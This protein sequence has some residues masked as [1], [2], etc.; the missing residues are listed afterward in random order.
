MPSP[1]LLIIDVQNAIDDPSWGRDRNNPAAEINIARLLAL[2]RLRDWPI[3]HVRHASREPQSTYRPGQPGF[4]FKPEVQPLPG[5]TIVEKSTN[6]AFIGTTL[7]AQLR[8]SKID[9]LVLTGVIT[10]N[11]VE[12]TA[13]MAG[14]LGFRTFV[15]ADATATFGRDDFNGQWR[16]ADDV[17]AMSLANLQGEYATIVNTDDIDAALAQ[18][19]QPSSAVGP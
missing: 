3:V 14:N 11:S 16:S 10:N 4:E 1:A 18:P 5:E 6:S 19:F 15:V 12:A 13:R 17:H 9:A 7:E 2:W 8:A